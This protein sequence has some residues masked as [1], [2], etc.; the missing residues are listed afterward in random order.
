MV[1][2][3][4]VP[5]PGELRRRVPIAFYVFVY[6]LFALP[7]I[8][9]LPRHEFIPFGTVS[10]AIAIAFFVILL[11]RWDRNHPIGSGEIYPDFGL[12]NYITLFRGICLAMCAG[13]LTLA[14]EPMRWFGAGFY[15]TAIIADYFDGFAARRLRRTSELGTILDVEF[16]S[17]GVLIASLSVVVYRIA[18]P[19]FVLVGLARYLFIFGMFLRRKNGHKNAKLEGSLS[20]RVAAGMQMG[21]MATAWWPV[22]PTRYL[23]VASF[24]FSGFFFASFIRDWLVVSRVIV[25]ESQFY[26]TAEKVVRRFL[27]LVQVFCRI[28]PSVLL[29][30][31]LADLP[32]ISRVFA[33]LSAGFLIIGALGRVAA[34]A[35]IILLMVAGS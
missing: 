34:M 24:V 6:L 15:T 27:P 28:A 20:G 1:D 21:F 33:C 12:P 22:I 31:H 23:T 19:W 10:F 26:G 18:G 17:A 5:H 25:K 8:I 16:D 13:A 3:K 32:P 14:S 35:L 7:F 4:I 2:L 9:L 30:W 29:M 11:F